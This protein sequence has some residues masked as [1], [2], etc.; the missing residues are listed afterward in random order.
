M[1]WI[2]NLKQIMSNKGI[3]IEKL[4]N[5]IASNGHSLSRNSIGNIINERNSPRI[6]T[7][8]MIADALE[9]DISILFSFDNKEGNAENIIG[10]IEYEGEVHKI[11]SVEEIKEL[12]EKLNN[13]PEAEAEPESKEEKI[14]FTDDYLVRSLRERG[15]TKSGSITKLKSHIYKRYNITVCNPKELEAPNDLSRGTKI[16]VF[17]SRDEELKAKALIK[18]MLNFNF[19]G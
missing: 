16:W 6:D 18:K 19:N 17:R 14:L 15:R 7:L 4:K 9:V 11:S 1:S 13:E 12:Y 3:N 5:R 2:K 10:F 8:Q